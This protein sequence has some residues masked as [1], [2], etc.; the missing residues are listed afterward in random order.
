MSPPAEDRPVPGVALYL[1]AFGSGFAVMAIEIAGARVMAPTYGLSAVPWTAVIGIILAALAAGNHVGG[2]WADGG[3]PALGWILGAAGLTATLPVVLAGLPSRA[4]E[5]LGFLPGAVAS[6]A[7]L[8]APPVFALGTVMPYL[9]RLATTDVT[10]VGRRAGDVGAAATVGSILG[11]FV[12]GFVLLP[13]FPLPALLAGTGAALLLM[14]ALAGVLLGRG[15]APPGPILLAVGVAAVG[16]AG[17]AAAPGLLHR[18][19]TVHASIQVTERTWSDGRLVREM[20]QNGGSSSAEYV[21]TGRPAHPYAALSLEAM[22]TLGTRPDSIL[23]LGGAALTLPVALE[24]WRPGL[25]IDVVELDPAATRLARR[26]FAYG[27]LGEDTGIRVVHGD[28]RRWLRSSGGRY[29]V[30]YLDVFDNLVTV[31][32]NLVTVEALELVRARLS[33]RGVVMANV[34]SP[35]AGPSAEFLRRLL[36]TFRTVFPAV[37]AWPVVPGGDPAATGNVLLVAGRTADALPDLVRDPVD[38]PSSGPPFTDAHAPVEYL[39]AR[40][41][42]GGLRWR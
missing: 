26:Y 13:A 28:A 16:L 24:A 4:L 15:P 12:T 35:T 5:G 23:V 38:T 39:Q 17:P 18:E 25:R 27:S 41:F 9:V 7:A 40:V 11:T 22:G 8:F 3:G 33:P 31:P 30:V 34:L 20:W 37:R 14:A 21:D 10:D 42:L 29:D 1:L 2:R 32:W 6:A 36:S 19:E